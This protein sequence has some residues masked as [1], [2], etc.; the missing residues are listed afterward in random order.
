MKELRVSPI[1]E[2]TVIDHIRARK[3]LK[4][5]RI[6]SL[7]S[8]FQ[9]VV[10]IL[11]NVESRKMGRKDV[12]KIEGIEL[13]QETLNKIALI[14][15]SATINII[16]EYKVIRKYKVKIPKEIYGIVKCSNPNCITNSGE[17]VT[18]KFEVISEEPLRIRCKYCGRIM[19]GEE[20]E[21]NII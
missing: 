6:L 10:S 13:D 20:I 5:F 4:V 1:R 8:E 12:I 21:E 3:A 11:M 17:N 18:T 2:G 9:N 14:S 7:P 15:P 19:S 16:Q